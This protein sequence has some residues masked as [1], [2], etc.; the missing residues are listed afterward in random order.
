MKG[1][2]KAGAKAFF[3]IPSALAY[4]AQSRPGNAANPKGIPPNSILIFEVELVAVKNT[5]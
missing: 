2:L 3:Y 1:Y 5:Q 4:G